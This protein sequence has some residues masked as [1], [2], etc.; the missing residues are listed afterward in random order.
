MV[1]KQIKLCF[2]VMTISF[3]WTFQMTTFSNF[4]LTGQWHLTLTQP[5][6]TI[7][8]ARLR[9]PSTPVTTTPG[10]TSALQPRPSHWTGASGQPT[11]LQEVQQQQDVMWPLWAGP[12]QDTGCKGAEI[13][14]S[15]GPGSSRLKST[16]PDMGK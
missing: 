9:A 14:W 5:A 8:P 7:P 2:Y 16:V 6:P 3:K 4:P 13:K 12:H 11:S 1:F 10:T 15:T